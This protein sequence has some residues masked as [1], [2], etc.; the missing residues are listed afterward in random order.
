MKKKINLKK[1]IIK[2]SDILYSKA[3][4]IIPSGTQTF[5]KGANQFV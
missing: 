1:P 3:L 5:S 2:N 4:K